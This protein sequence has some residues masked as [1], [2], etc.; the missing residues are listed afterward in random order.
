M[1]IRDS[2]KG[3][4]VDASL[5]RSRVLELKETIS[6]V[7][8][9][10]EKLVDIATPGTPVKD[11]QELAESELGRK[12]GHSVIHGVGV[13]PHEPLGEVLEKGNVVA[14]EPGIYGRYGVRLETT[15]AVKDEPEVL[16]QAPLELRLI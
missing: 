15:V 3:Y 2:Y 16:I 12:V 4:Y 13:L 6:K 5:T 11:F 10:L 7:K 9:T 1:C 14:I 8:G